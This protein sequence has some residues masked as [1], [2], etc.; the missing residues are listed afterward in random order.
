MAVS[1]DAIKKLQF[2]E[3]QFVRAADMRAE[4]RY[5]VDL[6]RRHNVAHHEWGI[7]QGL[8]LEAKENPDEERQEVTLHPGMAV[9]GFGRE[10]FVLAP[11]RID[12]AAFRERR[13]SKGFYSI[14]VAYRERSTDPPRGGYR[15]CDGREEW[16]RAEEG[17]E[18]LYEVPGTWSD[19]KP[20]VSSPLRPPPDPAGP[21]WPI[22]LGKVHWDP[23]QGDGEFL[24]SVDLSSRRYIRVLGEE[25]LSPS[26]TLL[27]RSRQH[28]YPL[29]SDPTKPYYQGV[30]VTLAGRL[31]IDR[32]LTAQQDAH[33]LGR[34]GIGT[35]TPA[36]KLHVSGGDIRWG[37]NSQL[38]AD[39][40]GSIELGGDAA[41][42]GT[43]TPYIDFHYSGLSQDYNARIINDA[44]GRLSIVASTLHASGHVGIGT[45]SPQTSL[46]VSGGDIR[47]ANNSQ[48]QVDQGGSIE[49]GGNSSTPGT[50][51]PYIDFHYAGLTQDYNTRIIND[52][53]G[54]LSVI[55]PTLSASGKVGI[56][57]IAP[58]H[59]VHVQRDQDATTRVLVENGHGGANAGT[60]FI[61][62]ENA[63]RAVELG[64]INSGVGS[65]RDMGP[66][67]AYL[68]ALSGGSALALNHQGSGPIT[69]HTGDWHERMRITGT[70]RVG[71]GTKT[72]SVEF[73]VV[74]DVKLDGKKLVPVYRLFDP[75]SGDHFYTTSAAEKATAIAGGYTDEGIGF[76]AFK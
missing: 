43:G 68:A 71:I 6:R 58:A 38:Q 41:T 30:G 51:T 10:I 34:V 5:H 37:N 75:G 53:D 50:G 40:G 76:Y 42:A 3:Y 39:Q 36:T 52:S 4:Q 48:L 19:A 44:D 2:Y 8:E 7:V 22:F 72:P 47:W 15:S 32:L 27:I 35:T 17:Y 66:N 1:D 46:H 64:Y 9:D 13:R 24:A 20:P 54:R 21:R 14:W 59:D 61:A 12:E 73:E 62:R 74:G 29:P 67:T 28:P 69:F 18:I 65:Y 63:T 11:A 70:G 56:G 45:P 57:T 25:L 49:L 26:E 31:T 60:R 23:T 55:A 33:I 16:T